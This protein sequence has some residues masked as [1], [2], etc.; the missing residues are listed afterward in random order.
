MKGIFFGLVVFV[1]GLFCE[2]QIRKDVVETQKNVVTGIESSIIYDRKKNSV[3]DLFESFYFGDVEGMLYRLVKPRDCLPRRI[4]QKKKNTS[5]EPDEPDN[6]GFK[7]I[8]LVN[9][10]SGCKF[11]VY[12]EQ[13][14][15][16]QAI[17][18]IAYNSSTT[19]KN[20]K[21]ILYENEANVKLD[22]PVYLINRN[23]GVFLN[24][25]IT[26]LVLENRMSELGDNKKRIKVSMISEKNLNQNKLIKTLILMSIIILLTIFVLFYVY[27][28]FYWDGSANFMSLG[29]SK[30]KDIQAGVLKESALKYMKTTNLEAKDI[31]ELSGAISEKRSNYLEQ[32]LTAKGQRSVRNIMGFRKTAAC[33]V[34]MD[35]FVSG[36]R[37]RYL[38]CGHVFHTECVDAWF[39]KKSSLCPV[40]N[41]D[42]R[43]V[44]ELDCG[45]SIRKIIEGSQTI[46]SKLLESTKRFLRR[47]KDFGE[48]KT[49]DESSDDIQKLKF[50]NYKRKIRVLPRF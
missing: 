10:E 46:G 21:G 23:I 32:Y 15:L 35:D 37:V 11:E 29:L 22:I 24:R 5:S 3:E 34:C 16:D 12:L 36:D 8:A 20:M 40:C 4:S 25:Q 27:L 44:M 42:T 18:I 2:V 7:K 17:G 30:N 28:N 33:P 41:F 31:K 9:L 6:N 50:N 47:K 38:P 26:D 14:L 43:K 45:S 48:M 1:F 39:V 49:Y 19:V 13:A